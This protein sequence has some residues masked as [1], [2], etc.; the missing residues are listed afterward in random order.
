MILP[1]IIAAA[2]VIVLRL[3]AGTD[4]ILGHICRAFWNISFKIVSVIP[5]MGWMAR[6]IIADTEEEIRRKEHFVSAGKFVDSMAADSIIEAGKRQVAERKEREKLRDDIAAR[7]GRRADIV[8][9]DNGEMVTVDGKN[10]TVQEIK[11]ELN[12][13]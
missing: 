3:L 6:F 11:A 10:Y 12:L 2:I 4:N 1:W 13:L 9:S 8:I 7:I 5:L